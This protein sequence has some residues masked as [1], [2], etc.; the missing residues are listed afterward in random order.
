MR[1]F[2]WLA[3]LFGW[4]AAMLVW[5]RRTRDPGPV[6]SMPARETLTVLAEDG[7]RLHVEVDGPAY[8]DRTVVFVHGVLARAAE[9]D[10]QWG[11]LRGTERV[12]RY[13][14]RGHGDSTMPRPASDIDQLGRDLRCVIDA[15][16]PTGDVVL[17]GHSMGGMAILALV[18]QQPEIVGPR[19]SAVA[20]V[21][22]GAGHDIP[23]HPIENAVRWLARRRLLDP[24]MWVLR[25]AAPGIE[26]VRP[27]RTLGMRG[28]VRAL[29][30]GRV[31]ASRDLV[32]QTQ[33]ML[34]QPPVATLAAFQ[35]ALLRLDKRAALVTLRS[36]PV[37]VVCGDADRLTRVEH[38]VAMARDL[39]A[40][41]ELTVLA[42]AGHS[43]AQSTPAEVTGALRRLLARVDDQRQPARAG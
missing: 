27:R 16:A 2:S 14:H 29:L 31:D 32:I 12:V 17:V 13:D 18:T 28:L 3:G 41:A 30:F 22:T 7:A 33:A 23:G 36:V 24:L 40:A 25:Q 43:I 19:V 38:S 26:M 37:A 1:R 8:A 4:L 42:G 34:E 15:V 35:G 21:G 10:A 6:P 20:L 11:A 5:A 39:G 9:W